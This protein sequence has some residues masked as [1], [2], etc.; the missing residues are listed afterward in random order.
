MKQENDQDSTGDA[1]D[2]AENGS[3]TNTNKDHRMPLWC[4]VAD[5]NGC[6]DVTVI[7]VG[8]KL[9]VEGYEVTRARTKV[10]QYFTRLPSHVTPDALGATISNGILTVT[11]EALVDLKWDEVTQPTQQQQ[12]EKQ[13]TPKVGKQQQHQQQ[14]PELE[15]QQQQQQ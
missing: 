12:Q 15:K 4:F 14:V 3:T 13:K 6:N 5:M 1:R 11:Q 8:D 10:V 9:I 2:F 7:P